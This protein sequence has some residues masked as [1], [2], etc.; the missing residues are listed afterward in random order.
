M[1]RYATVLMSVLLCSGLSITP[2]M[3]SRTKTVLTKDEKMNNARLGELIEKVAEDVSGEPGFWR[4]KLE[5]YQ[6]L[7][8]TD[9]RAD[10]MRVIVPVAASSGLSEA[11]LARMMQANF[12]S[13]LDARYAIARG[14]LWSAYIHP[15]SPLTDDQF[16]SGLAQTVNLTATYGKSYSS[17]ALIF[18]GGDSRELNRELYEKIRRKGMSI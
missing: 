16:V 3:S 11:D 8:I 10:R 15:L 18:G 14:T 17:G 5:G 1:H 6:V 9:E 7:V 12:D 4:F 13:A 2:S